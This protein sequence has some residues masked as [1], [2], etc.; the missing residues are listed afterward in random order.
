MDI[1]RFG[2]VVGSHVYQALVEN[3]AILIGVREWLPFWR[4]ERLIVRIRSDS[5]AAV[6][7][8][9]KERSSTPGINTVV[10]EMALDIVEGVYK[11]DVKEH[12]PGK[13]NVVADALS[14][15]AQPGAQQTLPGE[16]LRSKRVYRAV[17]DAMWWRAAGNPEDTAGFAA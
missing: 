17:R 16:L 2:I 8:W 13:F 6:G 9:T 1:I 12:L 4:N 15:M 5:K 14:R 3:L 7:A 10:R 11:I